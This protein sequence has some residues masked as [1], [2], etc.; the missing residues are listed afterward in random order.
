M[1]IAD[2]IVLRYIKYKIGANTK[3]IPEFVNGHLNFFKMRSMEPANCHFFYYYEELLWR[4]TLIENFLEV[5]YASEVIEM[6]P[7][8]AL[9]ELINGLL[10]YLHKMATLNREILNEVNGKVL[11]Y[12]EEVYLGKSNYN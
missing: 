7:H 5:F 11:K 4:A 6:L 10:S 1:Q 2:T 3:E 8:V 9:A 12:S